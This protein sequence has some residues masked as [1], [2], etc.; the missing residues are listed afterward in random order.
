MSVYTVHEPPLRASEAL[1]DPGRFIFVREGFYFWAFL[2][3][4]LWMLRH[5]MWLVLLG[6]VVIM[7]GIENGMRHAGVSA[8]GISLTTLLLSLLIGIEG[9]TL[10][11]FTLMRRGWKNVG[12]VVGD[13]VESAE[14]RFFDTW[15]ETASSKPATRTVPP[16]LPSTAPRPPAQP[17]DII[18][19]FPE[20]GASR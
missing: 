19:L 20:P 14:R 17:P 8:A 6:Y 4:P 1:P 9:A 5:R 15:V 18:G 3:A 10:R 7:L 11:R 13:D 2:L 16:P 12:L